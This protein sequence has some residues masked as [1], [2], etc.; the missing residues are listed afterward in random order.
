MKQPYDFIIHGTVNCWFDDFTAFAEAN[1]KTI[2][3]A[4]EDFE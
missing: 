3:M 4:E 2:P 1:D